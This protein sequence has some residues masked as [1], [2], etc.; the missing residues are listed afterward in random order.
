VATPVGVLLSAAAKIAR[1]RQSVWADGPVVKPREFKVWQ[2]ELEAYLRWVA[3][4]ERAAPNNA[5]AAQWIRRTSYSTPLGAA[6][7]FFDRMILTDTFRLRQ[8][9]T[10]RDVRQAVLD[11]LVRVGSVRMPWPAPFDEVELSHVFVLQDLRLNGRG[12]AG[13]QFA[14]IATSHAS[15][16]SILSWAGDL[17]SAWV[18]YNDRRLAARAAA[19]AG[20]TEPITPPAALLT[21]TGW[22]DAGIAGRAPIDDLLG[23]MDAVVLFGAPHGTGIE[24][25]ADLLAAYYRPTTGP[26]APTALHVSNRFSLF[27]RSANPAI[28]HTVTAAG[29]T[30]GTTA[31]A[32]IA[33]VIE[34]AAR[35]LL[36]AARTGGAISRTAVTAAAAVEMD[37]RSPWGVAMRDELARRFTQFLTDGLAGLPVT[38]PS[39]PPPVVPYQGYELPLS[40]TSSVNDI[41]AVAQFFLNWTQPHRDLPL[42]PRLFTPLNLDRPAGVDATVLGPGA[43]TG[44]TRLQLAD[45]F[46]DLSRVL[47]GPA[48]PAEHRDL[49]WLAN[50]TARASVTYRIVDFDPVA[51][52]VTVEGTP[53][54]AGGSSFWTLTHRPS[55]ILVQPL[56]GRIGGSSGTKPSTPT[57]IELDATSDDLSRINVN[58][59]TIFL[60]EENTRPSKVF[61]VVGVDP[62]LPRVTVE[63]LGPA[64]RRIPTAWLI[65]AGVAETSNPSAHTFTPTAGGCDHYDGLLFTV[66]ANTVRGT[67]LPWTSF[68]SILAVGQGRSSIR[69]N[70]RYQLSSYRS[71]NDY[72][73][74]SYKVT[75]PGQDDFVAQSRFYLDGIVSNRQPR[76]APPDPPA[77]VDADGKPLVRLHYGNQGGAG[78]GSGGGLVSPRYFELRTALIALHQSE[79][80]ALGLAADA[81]LTTI[82]SAATLAQS[83][84]LYNDTGGQTGTTPRWA[85]RL[86]AELILI[87]PDERPS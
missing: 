36:L 31:A 3:E 46:R 83:M 5:A 4:V 42:T 28:P 59:D 40:A 35:R 21:P 44:T 9:L 60:V 75:D 7:R 51:R 74:F 25:L 62:V 27:V 57:V 77:P 64:L 15:V 32:E 56:G 8:P 19:G 43:A 17:G 53:T 34:A 2:V 55:L 85:G 79:R 45:D 81:D 41:E 39:Q 69:G 66:Y 78:T 1:A 26:P 54:L 61:R 52:V 87:R 38:W 12:P 73:N 47:A 23:D 20:W 58:L 18:A 33:E 6:G 76:V 68:A 48:A 86:L 10:T 72:R 49:L 29:V 84:Q 24:P 67:P 80:S 50:D 22:L 70:A 63:G 30:L 14:L 82:S 71:E 37:L 65:G 11:G 16:D 13:D